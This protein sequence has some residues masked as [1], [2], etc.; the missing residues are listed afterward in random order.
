MFLIRAA[1]CHHVGVLVLLILNQAF[2]GAVVVSQLI[3][4]QDLAPN[5]S[6]TVFGM[7]NFFGMMTGI[8]VPTITGAL[9]EHYVMILYIFCAF[10]S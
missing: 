5:F 9:N 10:C 2:N 6:G 1:G 7:M 4:P 8:F 3:N